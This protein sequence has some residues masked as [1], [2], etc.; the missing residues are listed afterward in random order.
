M[1]TRT[2][3]AV[4]HPLTRTTWLAMYGMDTATDAERR[5]FLDKIE[6]APAMNTARLRRLREE[7]AEVGLELDADVGVGRAR[8]SPR[9]TTPCARTS[10][11]GGCRASGAIIEPTTPPETWQL[12][13]QLTVT[14]RPVE[15]MPLDGQPA[16]RRR[17]VELAD[18]A[19]VRRR[20]VGRV[21][22][23]GR[24]RARPRRARRDD[25]R[26]RRAA[27]PE[28]D[29]ARRRRRSACCAGRA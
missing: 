17:A 11:S 7:L 15:A 9:S 16:V 20:R 13:T 2:L 1:V 23:A 27:P 18:P 29:G 22:P 21:R 14:R 5:A 19:G 26:G 3:R 25:G 6:R 4:C 12:G 24:L 28:R 8:A 10:T